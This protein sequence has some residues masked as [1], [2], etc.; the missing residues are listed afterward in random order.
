[1]CV[2]LVQIHFFY[3]TNNNNFHGY[4]RLRPVRYQTKYSWLTDLTSPVIIK[5]QF[6][7]RS[8]MARV[9]TN[10]KHFTMMKL[11]FISILR[12]SIVYIDGISRTSVTI[13][14]SR[15]MSRRVGSSLCPL[16]SAAPSSMV[17]R[18]TLLSSVQPSE[19]ELFQSP[20]SPH[21][22]W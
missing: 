13:F 11:L 19:T 15:P 8:N 16:P 3:W 14:A 21:N 18:H 7:G 22:Y 6:V 12:M 1:M 17:V 4:N 5:P 10:I 2:N 20:L 9:T